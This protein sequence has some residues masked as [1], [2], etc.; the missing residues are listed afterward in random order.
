MSVVV[1]DKDDKVGKLLACASDTP[2]L[3]M[4]VVMEDVSNN[5]NEQAEK[6]NVEIIS[7]Q[8]MLVSR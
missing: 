1:C 7:F 3:R 5:N 8:S 2:S 6:C 4:I